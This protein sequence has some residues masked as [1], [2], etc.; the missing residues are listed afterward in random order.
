MR[1]PHR[2]PI[3]HVHGNQ[4]RE[5]E[6]AL[7]CADRDPDLVRVPT[8]ADLVPLT[9][10]MTRTVTCAQRDLAVERVAELMMAKHIGC[11]P[12]VEEPGRPIGMITKQDFVEHWILADRSDHTPRVAADLMMPLAITLN[13]RATVAHAAAMM[14][15]EDIHHVAVVD[16]EGRLIGVVSSMDVVR[17]LARNDGFASRTDI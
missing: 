10:I 14:A 6:R 16:L 9:D 17:W 13:E 2:Q 8:I 1:D 7:H 4:G 5:S 3:L 11:V 15:S 12:V